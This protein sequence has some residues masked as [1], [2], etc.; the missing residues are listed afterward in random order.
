[1]REH[2]AEKADVIRPLMGLP[3]LK[4]KEKCYLL[5]GTMVFG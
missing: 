1:M 3:N 4:K 5:E 2:Y